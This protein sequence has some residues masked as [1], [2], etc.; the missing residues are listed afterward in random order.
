MEEEK[1]DEWSVSVNRSDGW[2]NVF[3]GIG[4]QYD[5]SLYTTTADYRIL[6]NQTLTDLWM[7]DG[8]GNRIV[9]IVADDM[10][11]KWITVPG[12][13]SEKILDA[14]HQ[15]HAKSAF[16]EALC[17]MRLYGGS[18]IV[19]GYRDGGNLD[20]PLNEGSIKS[21]DFLQVYSRDQVFL[22]E[23]NLIGD[24]NDP[25]FGE[26]EYFDIQPKYGRTFRVH[27]SRCLVFKGEMVPNYAKEDNWNHYWGMS[28]L[29]PIWDRISNLGAAEQGVSNIMLEFIVGKYKLENLAKM[30]AE[31][32][33]NE[34]IRR[35]TLINMGKSLI[36]A[37][38][39]GENEDYTR[40]SANMGGLADVL[41]RL[42]MFLAGV[43][44][45]P[46]T[47]LFGRSPAGEN[48]T[49][50]F[51]MR[52]YYDMVSSVQENKLQR[53]LQ[54]LVGFIA[55]VL[56]I[57]DPII[58][59]NPLYQPTQKEMLEMRKL[60]ADIDNIYLEKAVLTPE[61]VFTSRF[62]DGYSFETEVEP[63]QEPEEEMEPAKTPPKKAPSMLGEEEEEE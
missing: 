12:D 22:I 56:K 54:M 52:N 61:E 23:T 5:K 53:P 21:I 18:L 26:P 41:D 1:R 25:N 62:V 38:L 30:L 46:V 51:D 7:G 59:F 28:V 31:G 10:T 34:V 20:D 45:I 39:L 24:P 2:M 37:V 48:A 17:W 49:G 35:L 3:A 43:S 29:Q 6:S 36:N 8:L 32:R 57:A 60:Q 42:M 50:E 15:L 13:P 4:G 33:E 58:E 16:H 63:F 55:K 40:D 19:A 27:R 11:R 14:L 9:K 44:G 47:K